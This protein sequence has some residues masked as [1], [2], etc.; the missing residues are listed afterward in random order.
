MTDEEAREIFG[1][2]TDIKPLGRIARLTVQDTGSGIVSDD[3]RNIFDVFF[4]T[5]K[6]KGTGLG[7]AVT[8]KI[9]EE[10]GGC[11]RVESE[12]GK[13]TAFHLIIPEKDSE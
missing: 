4:S 13:G 6:S 7:L 11:V 10:H 12:I 1:E 2:E 3:L 8:Q 5:K 9:A